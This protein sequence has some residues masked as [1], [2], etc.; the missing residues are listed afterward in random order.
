MCA[1]PIIKLDCPTFRIKL[2]GETVEE[3]KCERILRSLHKIENCSQ[4]NW[5]NWDENDTPLISFCSPHPAR[6]VYTEVKELLQLLPSWIPMP[7]IGT[8]PDGE[9]SFEW[10]KNNKNWIFVANVSGKYKIKYA[11]LFGNDKIHGK[12]YFDFKCGL[13]TIIIT[14]LKRLFDRETGIT[15]KA[16][17]I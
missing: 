4:E 16:D 12:V 8:D 13:P 14:S 2:S 17:Q 5:D 11:G 7:D 6:T 3:L 1:F 9:I 10:R 15:K